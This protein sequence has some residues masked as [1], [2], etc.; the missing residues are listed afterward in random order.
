MDLSE[1]EKALYAELVVQIAT[2]MVE[3]TSEN[4]DPAR[5]DRFDIK[6]RVIE[7][8]FASDFEAACGLLLNVGAVQPLNP[9]QTPY[10]NE[11][12]I[13]FFN[14]IKFDVPE[15]REH[16]CGILPDT[17]PSLS[18]VIKTFLRLAT[19]YGCEISTRRE[20][21]VA[22]A[23]FNLAFDLFVECGYVE[24]VGDNF[25]WTSK[26]APEMIATYAWNEDAVSS[27]E[28]YDAEIEE[29]W[30]TIPSKF[31]EAFFADG[32]VDIASLS[33]VISHFWCGGRWQSTALH[34]G[35]GRITLQGGAVGK[36]RD[37]EKKFRDSGGG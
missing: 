26:I 2:R 25:K 9:D 10:E 3:L 6:G 7:Q 5:K 12:A 37:L 4:N 14:R 20:A 11:H 34:A 28:L 35:D 31:R 30:R 21:F 15:L 33:A 22:P 29:M 19:D 27:E 13:M 17:A 18:A 8:N 24:R 36:A 23:E 1:N 32:P 16:L